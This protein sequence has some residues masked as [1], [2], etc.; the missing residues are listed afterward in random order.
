MA[1]SKDNI[2]THGLSGKLGNMLVFSQS[3]GKTIVR[4]TPR[5]V[6]EHSDAQKEH[7]LH[8]QEAVIYA[9]SAMQDA[10]MHDEYQKATKPGITAYN[11]AVADMLKAPRIDEVD[12]TKY[13]GRIGDKIVIRAYDDFKV[14]EVKVIIEDLDGSLIEEGNAVLDG[15]G[16]D[17]VYTATQNNN[18]L[19]GDKITVH[20]TDIPGN[21]TTK[22]KIEP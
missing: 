3:A 12:I 15:N 7:F 13:A 17:W 5:K 1:E 6:K 22:E 21:L 14:K 16:V 2:I 20:A 19:H 18:E 10:A 8:F 11:M 4:K 9:R